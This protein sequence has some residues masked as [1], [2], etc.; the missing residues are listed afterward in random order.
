MNKQILVTLL[1]CCII[2]WTSYY[3]VE[4]NKQESIERQ[5]HLE[6]EQKD[7]ELQFEKERQE[8]IDQEKADNQA[9]LDW[10][11]EE[12]EKAYISYAKL[13]WTVKDD[14]TIFAKSTVWDNAAKNKKVATDLCFSKYKQ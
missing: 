7:K 2:L 11:L 6:I 14:W 10:C 13:N 5:K 8:K 3:L 4:T 9:N 1:L 12:A